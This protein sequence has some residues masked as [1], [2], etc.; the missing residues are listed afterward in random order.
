MSECKICGEEITEEEE[1]N[2]SGICNDCQ[3]EIFYDFDAMLAYVNQDPADFYVRWRYSA[4]GDFTPDLTALCKEHIDREIK[5]YSMSE[6]YN[7]IEYC[8]GDE[9]HYIDF[10]KEYLKRGRK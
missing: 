6:R 7:L 3:L 2:N 5:L 9:S 4:E 1:Y 10:Y 8:K